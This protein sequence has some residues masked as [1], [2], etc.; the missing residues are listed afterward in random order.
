M[1]ANIQYLITYLLTVIHEPPYSFGQMC[2]LLS[3][4]SDDI[5]SL[6]CLIN[7]ETRKMIILNNLN[8]QLAAVTSIHA[9]RNALDRIKPEGLFT[10]SVSPERIRQG[11]AF[12]RCLGLHEVAEWLTEYMGVSNTWYDDATLYF[13]KINGRLLSGDILAEVAG[14]VLGSIWKEE[15]ERTNSIEK[16]RR[17]EAGKVS[18]RPPPPGLVNPSVLELPLAHRSAGNDKVLTVQETKQATGRLAELGLLVP[19]SGHYTVSLNGESVHLEEGLQARRIWNQELDAVRQA[20]RQRQQQQAMAPPPRPAPRSRVNQEATPAEEPKSPNSRTND[21]LL[22]IG[23]DLSLHKPPPV[24]T[25][26]STL[27]ARTA[28]FLALPASK[29]LLDAMDKEDIAKDEEEVTPAPGSRGVSEARTLR[30][31]SVYS[32]RYPSEAPPGV[33]VATTRTTRGNRQA[34]TVPANPPP[35]SPRAA[36]AATATAR[37]AR[38]N[39]QASIAP[40]DPQ[41]PRAAPA[42]TST[43]RTTRGNRQASTV[44]ATP[45]PQPSSVARGVSRRRQ[46]EASTSREGAPGQP[47][48]ERAQNARERK[49]PRQQVKNPTPATQTAQEQPRQVQVHTEAGAP[50]S[51][52]HDALTGSGSGSSR[53]V[54]KAATTVQRGE[55]ARPVAA[56]VATP[57]PAPE[58]PVSSS[59]KKTRIVLKVGGWRVVSQSHIASTDTNTATPRTEPSVVHP[60]SPPTLG[61]NFTEPTTRRHRD[62]SQERGA[63]REAPSPGN[64]NHSL[65]TRRTLFG[66]AREEQHSSYPTSGTL[67]ASNRNQGR[68]PTPPLGIFRPPPRNTRRQ[69]Q[70]QM[71]P[72]AGLPNRAL[73]ESGS[74]R[75]T[76]LVPSGPSPSVTPATIPPAQVISPQVPSQPVASRES[77]LTM[78]GRATGEEGNRRASRSRTHA[79]EQ[80]GIGS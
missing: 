19:V 80:R 26:L 76:S 25:G 46:E 71:P 54:P 40:A 48:G 34:S 37:T 70:R 31:N 69:D 56:A 10:D 33:P 1:P 49:N 75:Q 6:L 43:A 14:E 15:Q 44:P 5:I 74:R 59:Q 63:T 7:Q 78:R 28:A 47:V 36:P 13:I 42:A 68:V 45:P 53:P 64:F 73:T 3:L 22:S 66:T 16:A 2:R 72:P 21:H 32:S 62:A 58:T 11:Q 29:D 30:S 65:P 61:R 41:H 67:S 24:E 50:S 4:S 38:G 51:T 39:R 27:E 20:Q 23:I 8:K 9:V 77:Q 35:R 17:A 60:T 57:S 52:P 18:M 55:E 12:L 79:E